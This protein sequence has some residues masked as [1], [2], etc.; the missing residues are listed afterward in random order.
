MREENLF[1]STQSMCA[2]H[3]TYHGFLCIQADSHLCKC[4]RG[5]A[6]KGFKSTCYTQTFFKG[7]CIKTKKL[8]TLPQFVTSKQHNLWPFVSFFAFLWEQGVVQKN[9]TE[10]RFRNRRRKHSH[11]TFSWSL[12]VRDKPNRWAGHRVH[13]E[14]VCL[15]TR[16]SGYILD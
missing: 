2:L 13:S 16:L 7:F 1:S 14:Q 11:F 6:K 15:H 4:I 12:L 3:T 5:K 10:F 9:L 8:K